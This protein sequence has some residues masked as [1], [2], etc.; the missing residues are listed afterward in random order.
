MKV[1]RSFRLPLLAGL[2]SLASIAI[3]TSTGADAASC[4]S[5]GGLDTTNVQLTST[6]P[7]LPGYPISAS[8]CAGTF[9]GNEVGNGGAGLLT[10]LNTNNVFGTTNNWV[11]L[12]ESGST[13]A[14]TFNLA[15]KTFTLNFNPPQSIFAVSLFGGNSWAVYLFNLAGAIMNA[16]GSYS[17]N[18][19][20]N[21]GGNIP[22]LSHIGVATYIPIPPTLPLFL[23]GLLG[24][25][26]LV[27][28]R[29][30]MREV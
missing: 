30:Q 3:L 12:G 1:L 2:A 4:G 7:V 18:G 24:F 10:Q 26:F 13:S 16:D 8:N 9:A 17:M 27:R 6:N 19:I 21:N 15:T 22:D 28:R 23:T 14:I 5:A 29:R 11:Y 20:L 25:G